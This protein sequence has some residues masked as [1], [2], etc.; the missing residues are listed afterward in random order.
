MLFE[1]FFV[2]AIMLTMIFF[3]LIIGNSLQSCATLSQNIQTIMN[4]EEAVF[5]ENLD[6]KR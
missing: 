1:K 6:G 5:Y 3:I 4:N 2:T